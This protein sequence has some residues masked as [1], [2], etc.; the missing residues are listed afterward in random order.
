[1]HLPKSNQWFPKD[2]REAMQWRIWLGETVLDDRNIDMLGINN[3]RNHFKDARY[4][5]FLLELNPVTILCQ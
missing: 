2:M 1:M 4:E 5:H 3:I